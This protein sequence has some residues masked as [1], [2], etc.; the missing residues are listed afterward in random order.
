MLGDEPKIFLFTQIRHCH[1]KLSRAAVNQVTQ[2]ARFFRRCLDA[3][4]KHSHGGR[5]DLVHGVIQSRYQS[6]DVFAVQRDDQRVHQQMHDLVDDKIAAVL[7]FGDTGDFGLY[8]FIIIQK[9]LQSVGGFEQ[10]SRGFFKP[11]VELRLSRQKLKF[12][13]VHSK[14]ED[15]ME[16]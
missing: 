1:M 12:Y 8:V 7:Q 16:I 15:K 14:S 4:N 11:F 2:F 3:K 6:F 13:H 9:I 10:I 5:F